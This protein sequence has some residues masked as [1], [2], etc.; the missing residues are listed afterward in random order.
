[1]RLTRG[2]FVCILLKDYSA[3]LVIPD[4]YERSY[5]KDLIDILLLKMG[6]KQ[7]CVQQAS[8]SPP[9]FH[10]LHPETFHFCGSDLIDLVSFR[11]RLIGVLGHDLRSRDIN[12]LCREH[13]SRGDKYCL[14][15]RWVSRT[16]YQV[17]KCLLWALAAL[18][19]SIRRFISDS[20]HFRDIPPFCPG[21]F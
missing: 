1:M 2:A 8:P 13:R 3:V 4:F 19:S 18:P 20:L 14:R 17:R 6:F 7:I 15:R 5:V 21:S 11:V 16:G 9:P 12:R 10:F